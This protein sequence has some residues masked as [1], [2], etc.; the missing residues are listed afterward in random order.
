MTLVGQTFSIVSPAGAPVII[1]IV[2]AAL[3]AGLGL[4]FLYMMLG[5]RRVKYVV[6]SDGLRIKAPFYGRALGR[7]QLELEHARVLSLSDDE[8]LKPKKFK[9]KN[10]IGLPGNRVGWFDLNTGEKGLLFVS[11]DKAL[12]LPTTDG[13]ALLVSCDDPAAL[14]A[15]VRG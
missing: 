1:V 10:G 15:A 7:A 8:V 14:L 13:Y 4:L 6:D 3:L 2:V 5:V 9:K 11:G 12:Y